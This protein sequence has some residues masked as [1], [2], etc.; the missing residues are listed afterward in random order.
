MQGMKFDE[1]KA[2]INNKYNICDIEGILYNRDTPLID[3]KIKDFKLIYAKDLSGGKLYPYEF[4]FMGL[5]YIAFNTF[6]NE[7]V[8][9]ENAMWMRDYLDCMGLQHYDFEQLIK[10]M[11]GWNGVGNFWIKF[12]DMGAQC[13]NDIMTQKYPIY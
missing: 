12:K 7:R 5:K 4:A 13:W 9:R 2:R 11:N 3:F 10:K 1:S 8:V 6:F